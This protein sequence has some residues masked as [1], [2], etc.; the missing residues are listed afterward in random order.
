MLHNKKFSIIERFLGNYTSEIYGRQL[1][2]K[3]Q[4]S[5]KA[6]ALALGGLEKEHILKSRA[7]GNIKYFRLNL[8]NQEI[9]DVILSA[10]ISRKIGF[11]NKHRKLAHIFKRDDRIIGVFGSYAK[12]TEKEDSD[13]D[14][15]IIGRKNKEDYNLI[16][17]KLDLRISIKYFTENEFRQLS[18]QKNPLLGEIFKSHIII[19]GFEGFVNIA[20]RDYYGIN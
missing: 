1:I 19:F 9:K 5:Q 6:I 17:K 11:F 10:E 7:E 4:L 13:I 20:W 14:L 2:G 12:G 3:V 16:G 15:F 18:K 8:E